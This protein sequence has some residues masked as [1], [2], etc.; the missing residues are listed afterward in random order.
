MNNRMWTKLMDD[1]FGILSRFAFAG[2]LA[3]VLATPVNAGDREKVKRIYDRIAGVPP[4]A[5]DMLDLES[6]MLGTNPACAG[7][8]LTGND[9]G[10]ECAAYIAMEDKSF[11][12]VTLK[13]DLN[14]SDGW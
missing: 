5:T 13:E 4:T 6:A 10:A 11:Y 14:L 2:L 12:N 9:P 7:Y 1:V 8:V 3:A